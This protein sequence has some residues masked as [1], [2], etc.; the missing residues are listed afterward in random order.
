[1]NILKVLLPSLSHQKYYSQRTRR[2]WRVKKYFST[3]Y[4]SG[5]RAYVSTVRYVKDRSLICNAFE[6]RF[7]SIIRPFGQ[8]RACKRFRG[9]KN[10]RVRFHAVYT[11]YMMYSRT[12]AYLFRIPTHIGYVVQVAAGEK[13]EI[14][15]S[16]PRRP[17]KY[18][19]D[20]QPR[21]K[22]F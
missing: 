9:K 3:D 18:L 22:R 4:V 19:F 11:P 2:L 15:T 5:V 20:F 8:H 21:E 6:L 1:M 13:M 10:F 16:R 14:K 17:L 12:W 7:L